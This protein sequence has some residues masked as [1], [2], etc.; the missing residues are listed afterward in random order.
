MGMASSHNNYPLSMEIHL[1]PVFTDKFTTLQ[2]STGE[3]KPT[4]FLPDN[5]NPYNLRSFLWDQNHQFGQEF[6]SAVFEKVQKIKAWAIEHKIIQDTPSSELDKFYRRHFSEYNALDLGLNVE[7][8]VLYRQGVNQLEEITEKLALSASDPVLE[9]RCVEVITNLIQPNTLSLCAGGAGNQLQDAVADLSI[10]VDGEL[11]TIRRTITQN[12]IDEMIIENNAQYPNVNDPMRIWRGDA[13]HFVAAISDFYSE[14]LGLKK[15]NDPSAHHAEGNLQH[16]PHPAYASLLEKFQ[17]KIAEKLNIDI[18]LIT[19]SKGIKGIYAEIKHYADKANETANLNNQLIKLL[20]ESKENN[21]IGIGILK[22]I[23]LR[24]P[25][26]ISYVQQ[27]M[28]RYGEDEQFNIFDDEKVFNNEYVLLDPEIVETQIN[29]SLIRRLNKSGYLNVTEYHLNHKIFI[30]PKGVS[31]EFCYIYDELQGQYIQENVAASIFFNAPSEE[32]LSFFIKE[33]LFILSSA[34]PSFDEWRAILEHIPRHERLEFLQ[35]FNLN[36]E[37]SIVDVK[38][39][40]AVLQLLPKKQ[41]LSFIRESTSLALN[42]IIHCNYELLDILKVIPTDEAELVLL[43]KNTNWD[44]LENSHEL[45]DFIDNFIPKDERLFF[46][47]ERA[48][49]LEKTSNNF[50]DL[51]RILEKLP[52]EQRILFLEEFKIKSI[53][54]VSA[55]GVIII[56]NT[57]PEADRLSF[58]NRLNSEGYNII[59][60]PYHIEQIVDLIPDHQRLEFIR[61]FQLRLDKSD[62]FSFLEIDLVQFVSGE[63]PGYQYRNSKVS[64]APEDKMYDEILLKKDMDLKNY[65]LQLDPAYQSS[66]LIGL[67]NSIKETMPDDPSYNEDLSLHSLTIINPLENLLQLLRKFPLNQRY[68]FFVI[69]NLNRLHFNN[70]LKTPELLDQL[71]KVF[72]EQ[73]RLD[74]L[75]QLDFHIDNIESIVEKI[76]YSSKNNDSILRCLNNKKEDESKLY[77][78][79]IVQFD[80]LNFLTREFALLAKNHPSM[81]GIASVIN[82]LK[83]AHKEFLICLIKRT[84]LS[85]NIVESV[86]SKIDLICKRVQPA[87]LLFESLA[88]SEI[89]N[90][91]ERFDKKF[92]SMPRTLAKGFHLERLI[93]RS[94]MFI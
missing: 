64:I 82:V 92:D 27:V 87:H 26:E 2:K 94:M 56:L 28:K 20:D 48:S 1:D 80:Q 72:P 70:F 13:T 11:A 43:F 32:R 89:K 42:S 45:R 4:V 88:S 7:H 78:D 6:K 79:A 12:I 74:V 23:L 40:I 52:P 81:S 5:V 46:L 41:R 25:A 29:C 14:S 55:D 18:L 53:K 3:F 15:K 59:F 39:L 65:L 85:T 73:E 90:V 38:C 93:V 10:D 31:A 8:L 77:A 71:L 54:L 50:S 34:N 75:L 57:L 68:K 49:L 47:N 84:I 17:G 66:G 19:I 16:P 86:I 33:K 62:G 76:P 63:D 51:S 37:K 21:S 22:K 69:S 36:L 91:L 35:L 83:D 67:I 9:K 24:A 44:F 61:Q 60:T 58:I 30:R